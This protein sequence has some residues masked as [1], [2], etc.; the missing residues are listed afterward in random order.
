MVLRARDSPRPLCDGGL[1]ITHTDSHDIFIF[2]VEEDEW[3]EK[4]IPLADE[5]E[6]CHRGDGGFAEGDDDL[7][8][9]TPT[10]GPINLGGFIQV[11]GDAEDEL[12]HEKNVE[13][14]TAKP[15]RN[16]QRVEGVDPAKFLKEQIGWDQRDFNRQHNG[17]EGE[18]EE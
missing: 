18:E 15:R 8:E 17:G 3:V 11:I 13:G 9:N 1:Q 14:P 12:A 10:A 2:A 4:V 5:A 6:R 16:D 7:P